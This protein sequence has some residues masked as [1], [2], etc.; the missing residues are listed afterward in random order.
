MLRQWLPRGSF[1]LFLLALGHFVVDMHSGALPILFPHL[2]ESYALSYAQ[3]GTLMLLSQITSSVIQPIFGFTSDRLSSKWM[4]PASLI[5]TTLGLVMVGTANT[6]ATVAMAVMVMGLGIAAFHPE[7]SKV[8]YHVGGEQKG[9]AMSFFALGGNAG[10]AVGPTLMAVGL[11]FGKQLGVLLF[12]PAALVTAVLF[13]RSLRA[14]YSGWGDPNEPAPS[15]ESG[16]GEDDEPSLGSEGLSGAGTGRGSRRNLGLSRRE[17]RRAVALLLVVIFLRSGAH[18]SLLTFVPLYFTNF[19]GNPTAY[20]SLG[21][22]VFLLAGA[23]GTAVGG[24]V[25]DRQGPRRVVIISL[26]LSAPLIALIPLGVSGMFPIV[27][28]GAI[29][30]TLVSS[31]AVTTVMGQDLLPESVGLASGLTLGFSVGTGGFTVTLLGWVGDLWGLPV[32]FAA[33]AALAVLGGAISLALPRDRR[34]VSA[35]AGVSLS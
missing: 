20:S 23:L 16:G 5:A 7:A 28:L 10:L 27:L 2:Q 29:G 6:Y 32:A 18:S 19:L 24:A 25:G 11:L 31:W 26:L 22:T 34:N 4:L 3:V 33:I 14:M 13:M 1:F 17:R 21:L 9:K 15:S 35:P 12:L 8:V 30:F